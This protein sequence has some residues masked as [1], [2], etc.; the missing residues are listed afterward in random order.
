MSG[1]L[2]NF[3]AEGRCDELAL[4]EA[5]EKKASSLT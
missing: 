4:D 2:Q 1:R 5:A 3:F